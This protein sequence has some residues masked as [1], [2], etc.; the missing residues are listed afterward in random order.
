MMMSLGPVPLPAALVLLVL[1]TALLLARVWPQRAPAQRRAAAHLALD[2]ALAGL[3]AAR[4]AF[5][6]QHL[7]AYLSAPWS[8]L[9]LA[10]GGYQPLAGL[11]CAVFWGAWKLRGQPAL[12]APVAASVLAAVLGW[13]A[14]SALLQQMHRHTYLPRVALQ[15]PFGRPVRL[16]ADDGRPLVLNLWASWCG[17]CVRE[18]PMLAQMQQANPQVRFVFANQG[19]EAEVVRGF[20]AGHARQLEGVLLDPAASLSSTL[21]VQAYP[22]T[23]LFSADGRLQQL[24][25]GELTRAGL[26]HKLRQ[27]R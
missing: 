23:L 15:D 16:A 4:V 19:E 22:A 14:G 20:I 3:L 5:I 26:D 1:T 17:P 25:M 7:D 12:R 21:G 9:A 8:M 10:D 13:G 24:H 6:V 18:M 2:M 11:V 27:L